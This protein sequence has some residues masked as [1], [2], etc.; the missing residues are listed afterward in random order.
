[1]LYLQRHTNQTGLWEA[2]SYLV[3]AP[4]LALRQLTFWHHISWSGGLTVGLGFA[5]AI[6]LLAGPF[7]LLI[8]LSL[9]VGVATARWVVWGLCCSRHQWSGEVSGS[10]PGGAPC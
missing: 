5:L 9:D 2:F 8:K 7:A 6:E 10:V 4:R 1:V 3:G